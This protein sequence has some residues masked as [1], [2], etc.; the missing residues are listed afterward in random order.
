MIYIQ[1]DSQNSVTF[2]HNKPFDKVDG[3][4]KTTEELVETGLLLNTPQPILETD[5]GM[6][7]ILKYNPYNNSLYYEYL[8]RNENHQDFDSK[9]KEVEER[10]N[11]RTDAA[12][13][14]MT[15]LIMMM[16]GMPNV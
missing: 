16:G 14:E 10:N 12:I 1:I 4:G 15:Q 3:L 9:L 13:I 11:A 2:V 5:N 8:E 6:D 7:S